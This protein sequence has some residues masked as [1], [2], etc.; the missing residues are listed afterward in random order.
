MED[1]GKEERRVL[2]L[3]GTITSRD[4]EINRLRVEEAP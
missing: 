1:E 2:P 4:S 3:T